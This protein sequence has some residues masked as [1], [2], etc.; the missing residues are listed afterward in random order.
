MNPSDRSKVANLRRTEDVVLAPS[1]P[2]AR[3]VVTLDA[4]VLVVDNH[5]LFADA[6]RALLTSYGVEV[7]A[8]ASTGQE[9]IVAARRHRPDLVVLDLEL[10]DMHGVDVGRRILDEI[11]GT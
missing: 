3:R 4:R 10:P 9:A 7:V 2:S 11:P 8:L 1:H 5:R 6:L